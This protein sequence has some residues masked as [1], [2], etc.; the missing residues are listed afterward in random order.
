MNR[1]KLSTFVFL[2]ALPAFASTPLASLPLSFEATP[3]GGFVS[4]GHGYS[5]ALT[6]TEARF[7]NARGSVHMRLAGSAAN[8]AGRAED[9]LEGTS[10]YFLGNDPKQ[11]R[12][13]V[14]T[15]GR[16]RYSGVYPGIDLVYY[17]NPAQLE[18]DFVVTPGADPT[19]IAFAFEGASGVRVDVSGDLV[20]TAASGEVRQRRPHLYQEIDGQRR[21]IGGG[22]RVL[23]GNRIGF[24]VDRYDRN[25]A[26]VID[27]VIQFSTFYGGRI[28]EEA[29]SI[30]LDGA[31]NLYVAGLATSPDYPSTAEAVQRQVVGGT[32]IFVVKL[33]ATGTKVLYSTLI[34]GGNEESGAYMA[35]DQAGN[36]YVAGTTLSVNFPTTQGAWKIQGASDGDK[37]GFVVKLD[38]SG[39]NMLYSTRIGGKGAD[40]VNAVAIDFSGSAYVTGDTVSSDYPTNEGVIQTERKGVNDAFVTKLRPNGSGAIFSTYLGGAD[41][42]FIVPYES[43]RAIAV[44]RTGGIWV[45][46]ITTLR[47]FPVTSSAPQT[48]H[49]GQSDG[50]VTKIAAD[51]TAIVFST[52]LGGENVDTV[53]AMYVDT[54]GTNI[55]VVGDTL[56]A[57]FPATPQVVQ[58]F[59]NG[60][61][62]LAIPPRD[63]FVTKING[64]GQIV[65]STYLGGSGDDQANAVVGDAA[66]N[67]YVFG[68]TTS[69]DFPVTFDALQASLSL[70][71]T[72]EPYDAFLSVFTQYGQQLQ[73]STYLGGTRTDFGNAITRDAAGNIFV[74]GYTQS[75]AF[76]ISPG[77][78]QSTTGFGTNTAFITRIGEARA[79]ASQIVIVSGDKQTADQG[80]EV[81]LPLVVAV[82]DQFNNPIA[83]V[84]VNFSATNATITGTAVTTDQQGQARVLARLGDRPGPASVTAK[85][86][87]LTTVFT[88]TAQRV[89]PPLPEISPGGVISG[90]FS[91]PPLRVLSVG[92]RGAVLGRL[93]APDFTDVRPSQVDDPKLPLNLAGVCLTVGGVAARLAA[94]ST[95]VIEFVV[96]EIP[97][98]D[99]VPV[100]VIKNCGLPG[101]LRSDPATVDLRAFSP[102]FLYW[103]SGNARNPIFAIKE[104]GEKI[105]PPSVDRAIPAG[106]NDVI[107]V[108]G[109]GFGPTR[110]AIPAGE[111]TTELARTVEPPVLILDGRQI[112]GDQISYCG[113]SLDQTGLYQITFRIP[114]DVRNGDLALS[115]RFGLEQSPATAFVRVAGGLDL[116]PS[117]AVSPTRIDFGD[118]IIGQFRELPLT[119]GNAGTFPLNVNSITSALQSVTVTPNLVGTLQPGET[120][121]LTVRFTPVANGAVATTISVST[122]DPQQPMLNVPVTGTGGTLPPPDNP[123]PALTTLSPDQVDQGGAPFNLVVNGTGFVKGSVVE[124]AGKPRSTFFNHSAQLIAFVQAGDILSVGQVP[125][126]VRSPAPGG[127]LSNSLNLTVRAFQQTGVPFG[128]VNQFDSRA[129]PAMTSFVSVFSSGGTPVRNMTAD[130]TS[131]MEEGQP[132]TCTIAPAAADFPASVALVF[133]MNG[134]TAQEDQLLLKAAA[135]GFVNNLGAQDRVSIVHLEDQAR[136]LLPFTADKERVNTLIDLLR[137]VDPGNALYD[138][139]ANATAS[140]RDEEQQGRRRIVVLFTAK[141]N[142]SGVF[143]DASQALGVARASGVTVYAV[144]IGSGGTDV[145]LTG[146]LRQLTRDTFGQ[147]FQESSP[148][149]YGDVLNRINGIIQ[150]QY[151]I[152]TYALAI[153]GRTKPL[154]FTFKTPEGTVTA[155]RNYAPCLK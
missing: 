12:T 137:P 58:Q 143:N 72:G 77:A 32:D 136:P 140:F 151:A 55:Y 144:A 2:T 133:G 36:A 94:V 81:R 21:E 3:D 96:P 149:R 148:I 147:Y 131:C 6:S 78:L 85:F 80:A 127:G 42:S 121:L 106:P 56:S 119:V 86:G 116:N 104:S 62:N 30:A 132:V 57:R 122:D 125:V 71:I 24:A 1:T 129:C 26:L 40:T 65:Y 63:A 11:W 154:S 9:R 97:N 61:T 84:L 7:R 35:V 44:D 18:Y 47:D 128:I 68:T 10:N 73:F 25:R 88:L 87:D 38:P 59:L 79:P 145:N 8:A 107:T 13:G 90:G 102:E 110:P 83:G 49:L 23:S 70:G 134:I 118:V 22:Y 64:S 155:T 43:G 98:A 50:F 124:V 142:L 41:D 92:A 95:T 33:N 37:D 39:A 111:K 69:R 126:A 75:S 17:G 34:G 91:N 153:D 19:R 51:G 5:L 150:A 15:Y 31:G 135:K 112:P 146:F 52:F 138:A 101:E 89:G 123:R 117:A 139:V 105:G 113:L 29:R 20:L 53:N 130:S 48:T 152:N 99:N 114:Q 82:R 14:A 46:G 16:V 27:P 4:R 28:R 66:G 108:Y 54:F 45:A 93:F 141:D 100:V 103:Q 76:P 109:T 120:R 67:A 74:A 60:G 115:V